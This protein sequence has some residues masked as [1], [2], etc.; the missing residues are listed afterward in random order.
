MKWR[1]PQHLPLTGTGSIFHTAD[2]TLIIEGGVCLVVPQDFCLL[3]SVKLRFGAFK[4]ITLT[5]VHGGRRAC[6]L[7]PVSLSDR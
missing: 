1:P 2:I 6:S 7:L 4:H 3:L 5:T